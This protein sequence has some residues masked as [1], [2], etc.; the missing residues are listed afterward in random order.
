MTKLLTDKLIYGTKICTSQLIAACVNA[1]Y[2]MVLD[3]QK[4]FELVSL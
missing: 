4:F 3:S 1:E 2:D